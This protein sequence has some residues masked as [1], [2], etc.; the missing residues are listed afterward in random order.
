MIKKTMLMAAAALALTGVS[1]AAWA[2][3]EPAYAAARAAGQ[4]GEQPDGYL[5][6]VGASALARPHH[7]RRRCAAALPAVALPSGRLLLYPRSPT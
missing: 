4:V 7:T 1:A 3:R 6:V 2:Q 5:G